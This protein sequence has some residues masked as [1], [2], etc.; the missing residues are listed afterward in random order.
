MKFNFKN[1]KILEF[2]RLL[3]PP[4]K[5]GGLEI[6]DSAVRLTFIDNGKIQNFNQPLSPGD[7]LFTALKDLHSQASS[8][9]KTI[10]VV[11]S[12][13]SVG[14]YTQIFNL[15]LLR[16][17][18]LE[19]AAHLNLT[20]ISPIDKKTAYFDWQVV[21]Q[22]SSGSQEVLGAFVESRIVDGFVAALQKSNFVVVAVEFS[23]LS[24][25]RLIKERSSL[26]LEKPYL[27]LSLNNDGIEF[28]LIRNGN[29]YFSYFI[30][31]KTV[32]EKSGGDQVQFDN[33]KEVILIE[34]RRILNF[35][36]SRW[37]GSVTDLILF[38]T[39]STKEISEW[40]KDN[41]KFNIF[42]VDVEVSQ[43]VSLGAAM[44]GLIARRED[45]FISLA[46]VGTEENFVRNSI[47]KFAMIWRNA[48]LSTLSLL[49][50]LF[51]ITD[52]SLIRMNKN[53]DSSLQNDSMSIDLQEAAF[54]ENE[55]RTFNSLL[56]KVLLAQRESTS[57]SLIFKN[58]YGLANDIVVTQ[59]GFDSKSLTVSMA[60]SAN[61]EQ[62]ILNFKNILAKDSRFEDVSFPLSAISASP[63]GK[64][65][66]SATFKIKR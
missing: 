49:L 47:W 61:N 27:V 44:R 64:S 18:Q 54:L 63:D 38:S 50:L 45:N 13:P 25:A 53:L 62:S 7:D 8:I 6:S 39:G 11:V 51:L 17:E 20:M 16:D 46:K 59:L 15:P 42:Y 36:N 55:A 56:D 1:R 10:P 29:L 3:N 40:L 33:F 58:I 24:I 41:F 4:L 32:Q 2:I 19:E 5:I 26:D 57:L 9:Q 43:I 65:S 21:G 37:G 23:A 22:A 60:G 14:V 35:Y 12:F 31:W 30:S 52:L 66:F 28:L 34:L 48:V